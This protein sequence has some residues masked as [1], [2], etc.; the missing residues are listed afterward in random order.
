MDIKTF[1]EQYTE[2]K[3]ERWQIELIDA[4][5]SAMKSGKPMFLFGRDENRFYRQQASWALTLARLR[6]CWLIGQATASFHPLV[7]SLKEKQVAVIYDDLLIF[8]DH[9]GG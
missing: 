3:I 6:A 2:H 5:E 1:V 9:I 4:L 7:S 8:D